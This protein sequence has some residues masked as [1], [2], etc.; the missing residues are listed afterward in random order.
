MIGTRPPSWPYYLNPETTQAYGVAAAYLGANGGNTLYDLGPTKSL[1]GTL[2][3]GPTWTTGK[4]G[5]PAMSFD[6]S[7]DYVAIGTQSAL[8]LQGDYSLCAWAKY[9]SAPNNYARWIFG[10]DSDTL[11][12][13]YDFGIYDTA[14]TGGTVTLAH[15]INGTNVPA[16][17]VSVLAA[18]TPYHFACTFYG[19]T[20]SY[21]INGQFISSHTATSPA[22]TSATLWVGRRQY[23]GFTNEW[24]GLISA[25]S[26]HN[27][28]LSS[29]QIS[30]L[31]RNPFLLYWQPSPVRTFWMGAAPA[32]PGGLS[33]PI[34]AYHY[35]HSLRA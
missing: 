17:G 28:A 9:T 14:G 4:F 3:N 31:Y 29:A 8:D 21:Y 22:V 24:A 15:Q 5:E 32:A 25:P 1:H 19:T 33:I 35:N 18:N 30:E 16:S 6:G 20:L 13:S 23:A 11:G 34:A 7:D 26:I 2:T 12:R 10:K 27:R